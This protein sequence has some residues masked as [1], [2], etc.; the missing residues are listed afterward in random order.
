MLPL[1]PQSVPHPCHMHLASAK[2]SCLTIAR[3]G[4]GAW[5]THLDLAGIKAGNDLSGLLRPAQPAT[6]MLLS[7]HKEAEAGQRGVL[8][9]EHPAYLEPYDARKR[10]DAD[11]ARLEQAPLLDSEPDSRD[12]LDA[13]ASRGEASR[14]WAD[15]GA[16]RRA[17]AAWSARTSPVP[18]VWLAVA[19]SAGSNRPRHKTAQADDGRA[20]FWRRVG[21]KG[22]GHPV[23]DRRQQGAET[24]TDPD[25]T[26]WPRIGAP[27]H[28]GFGARLVESSLAQDLGRTVRIAFT[29]EGITCEAEA[30]LA[31]VAAAKVMPLLYAGSLGVD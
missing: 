19:A 13:K 1:L 16:R 18:G 24:P 25:G 22:G 2:L 26:R 14:A 10:L 30:P 20:Q 12:R 31:E 3:L 5:I 17:G 8:L 15:S 27:T 9:T 7:P 11:F 21:K 6:G 29:P 4:A 28:R 23:G